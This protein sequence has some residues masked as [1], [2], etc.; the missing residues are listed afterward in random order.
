MAHTIRFTRRNLPHWEVENGRY[1]VTVR[2]A[3]SLPHETVL[4]L[5][6]LHATLAHI[7]PRSP[8]FVALKRQIFHTLDK[9]LD[10]NFG[11]C[12]LRYPDAAEI[13]VSEFDSIS[14]EWNIA[15]PHYTVMPNHWHAL[16]APA[17]DCPHSLSEIMKRLKGRTAKRLRAHLGGRGPL[18]Q[19]EWFDRWLRDDAEWERCVAYIRNNPVKAGLVTEWT[20]HAWTK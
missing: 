9:H 3:D 16:L 4:R 17:A 11:A 1:F 7:E 19:R 8:E 15:V 12:P 13:V 10:A 14:T 2:C 6:E 5:G 18:W 20:Q